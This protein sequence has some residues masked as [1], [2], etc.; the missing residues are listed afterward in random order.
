MI[1]NYIKI[2]FRNLWRHKEFSMINIIGLAVGM[3]AGFLIFMYVKFELSYDHFN[4]NY[5]NVYRIASDIKSPT[6]TLHWSS[7]TAPVGPAIKA[8]YP[9]VE[10]FT[11]LFGGNYLVQYRDAKFQENNVQFAEP[12]LFKVFSFKLIKGDVAKAL[13]APYSVLMTETLAK[14]YFGSVDA[15]GKS[16]LLDGKYPAS[17]TGVMED[18]PHNSHI[19][20]DMLVSVSTLEKLYKGYLNQWGNYNNF[21]YLLLKKGYDPAKL[22][23]RLPA[24]AKKH[25]SDADRRQGMDYAYFLEPLRDVYMVSKRGGGS[26]SGSLSNVYIFSVIAVF[27]LLIACI[28]FINLTTARATER[29]KEVGIRK[30]IGAIRKQLT[31]QFLSESV[32]ICLISFLFSALFS[33][34]LL[35]LFNQLAG[36]EVSESIF[37]HGYLLQLFIISCVIGLTAGLYPALVLSGFKPI[38][39]L[40]GR[41]STTSKGIILRKG[42]VITQFTISIVLIIGTLVVYNQLSYMRNQD[43]GFKKDQ[44]LTIDFAGDSAIQSR[45]QVIKNELAKI[46]NVSSVT[47]SGSIP[48]FGNGVA[49]SK[50]ENKSGAMQEMNM[51]MYDVDYS[52]IHQFGMKVLAGR[53]FS[54]A[55]GTDTTKAIIINEAASKMLGFTNPGDAVGHNYEQWG[56][57]GKIIGVVK[58]FHFQGLQTTVKPLNMRIGKRGLNVFTVK[59][60]VKD[61][62]ATIKAIEDKWKVLAP[63]RPFNYVFVDATFNKLYA[64]DNT[65]GSLFLYFAILAIFISCL[66]LLGLASYSTIQRTREIGIR[67]VLGASV[68]GIVNMLSQEFMILVGISA[69]IAFPLAWYGM[70]K[71][72]RD[73]AYRTNIT[74][75]EFGLAGI[76]ALVIALTTVSFQA[77]KA[78]VANPVKSL[79]SE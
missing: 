53:V 5:D 73:F 13:E 65:F 1:R 10:E 59:I 43:L 61:V 16:L 4:E 3:T 37:R 17:V 42:L 32:I 44:M 31:I 71:W 21:T 56:R 12:S 69:V 52:F 46:P 76:I 55:F 57:K 23:S 60:G 68:G 26:E 34:L 63:E 74:W 79:R 78:A 41:F 27:I 72:L 29:A 47:A 19:K 70:D 77:I 20:F 18:V 54:E 51:N 6:E 9:E 64:S 15:I 30:V 2:A 25:I 33:F 49:Y 45:Y 7:T 28:N 48:G 38:T 66:G 22:Q 58:D 36:K 8:D 14:K 39:I 40:K 62:T 35:P 11:R 67:K 75:W 24:F 50:I